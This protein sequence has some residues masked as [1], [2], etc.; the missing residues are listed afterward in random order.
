MN[1]QDRQHGDHHRGPPTVTEDIR[2][3]IEAKQKRKIRARR[4]KNRVL[5]N[6]GM[7]GLVGWSVTIP[8][9]LAIAVGAWLDARYPGTASFTLILLLVGLGLGLANAW[10]WIQKE[11]RGDE[12]RAGDGNDE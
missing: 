3:T 9:V 1:A 5:M 2:K 4:N 11:S 10:Y 12:N 6:I 7:F 8:L